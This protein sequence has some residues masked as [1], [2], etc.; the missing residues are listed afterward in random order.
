MSWACDG[1]MVLWLLPSFGTV[2]PVKQNSKMQRTAM[3][4]TG[5]ATPTCTTSVEPLTVITLPET[6]RGKA[7]W[8]F[9]DRLQRLLPKSTSMRG[10]EI[11]RLLI[12]FVCYAC[13][14][15]SSELGKT[16]R[17]GCRQ[18]TW[19][20]FRR[21][22]MTMD[23]PQMTPTV[24]VWQGTGGGKG[25]LGQGQGAQAK[26]SASE[27]HAHPFPTSPPDFGRQGSGGNYEL[28]QSVQDSLMVVMREAT[29]KK[30]YCLQV[31]GAPRF[32]IVGGLVCGACKGPPHAHD[33]FSF[34]PTHVTCKRSVAL[35]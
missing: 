29:A 16:V 23:R 21:S 3:C 13:V 12:C 1:R 5:P 31:T 7:Q 34:C 25:K 10:F 17:Q 14:C 24:T 11:P 28:L 27:L 18:H 26:A 32:H 33:C 9:K 15:P 4:R 22:P 2:T 19:V 35:L 30:R 8:F 20:S 6:W